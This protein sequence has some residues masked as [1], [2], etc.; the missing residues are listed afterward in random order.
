M[1][2]QFLDTRGG[3]LVEVALA[4]PLLAL[5]M[6]GAFELGRVAHYAVE[7]ETAARAGAA[8]GS[9]NIGNAFNS[10][11]LEQAAKNDAPDLQTLSFTVTPGASCVCETLDLTTNTPSFNPS[12]GTISCNSPTITSCSGASGTAVQIAVRYV[13]VHTQANVNSIFKVGPLPGSY[14]IHCYSMLRVLPN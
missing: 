8:Y 7:T 5:M 2:P 13:S 1:K 4:A 9:T 3:A 14:T 10:N 11:T 6:L 12:S